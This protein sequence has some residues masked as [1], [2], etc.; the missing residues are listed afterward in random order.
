MRQVLAVMIWQDKAINMAAGIYYN[1]ERMG[2]STRGFN[3]R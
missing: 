3:N 1:N 2:T